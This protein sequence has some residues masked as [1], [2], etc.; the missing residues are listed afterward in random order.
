MSRRKI[1]VGKI[2]V[3]GGDDDGEDVFWFKELW[4][5]RVGY[6]GLFVFILVSEAG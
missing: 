3:G 1:P 5:I 4:Q 6:W 2:P